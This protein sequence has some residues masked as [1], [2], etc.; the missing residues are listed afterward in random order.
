MPTSNEILETIAEHLGVSAEDLDKQSLLREDLG[1]GP[2][3]LN[4]LLHELSQ[5]FKISFEPEDVENLHKLEDLLV[6]V[7]DNSLE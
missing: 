5:R 7:E 1:L 4:D 6:L 2:I 3:E